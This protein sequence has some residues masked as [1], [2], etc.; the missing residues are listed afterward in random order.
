MYKA[1]SLKGS[2]MIR[3]TVGVMMCAF[4][5]L[6]CVTVAPP[7]KCLSTADA[8]YD[9]YGY[10]VQ[11]FGRID[12]SDKSIYISPGS[13]GI[14]GH[15]KNVLREDGWE[16]S[17]LDLQKTVSHATE[18]TASNG[19][20]QTETTTET[21]AIPRYRLHLAYTYTC[22][23]Q[24]NGLVELSLIDNRDGKEILSI[25]EGGGAYGLHANNDIVAR[26]VDLL[27]AACA[28]EPTDQN[29]N[30]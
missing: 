6:G 20:R 3:A 4:A 5:L 26:F 29:A 23:T 14:K 8:G 30:R 18:T 15:I 16:I 2:T 27:H 19:S 13:T 22:R 24:T 12:T 7:A 25:S 21:V 9:A 10:R 11:K 17:G 1:F 28:A